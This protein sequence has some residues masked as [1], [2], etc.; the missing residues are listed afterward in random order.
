MNNIEIKIIRNPNI[1]LAG[2]VSELIKDEV[3]RANL[4][5]KSADEILEQMKL[6]NS[7]IAANKKAVV[8]YID[9]G[10]WLDYVEI[11]SLVVNP[12]LRRRGIG[13]RLV[14]YAVSLAKEKYRDKMVI[15]IAKPMSRGIFIRYGFKR[16]VKSTLK[17]YLW[18][19]C[20]DDACPHLKDFPD[21]Q[22]VALVLDDS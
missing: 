8:G 4:L 16:V 17:Q 21:C 22:C 12:E 20:I 14:S 3:E 1:T 7:M 6:G 19:L 9:L 10:E 11:R 15:A 18:Q 5:P 2:I 13:T